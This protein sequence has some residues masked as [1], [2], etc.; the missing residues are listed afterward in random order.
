MG[1]R[2]SFTESRRR[3]AKQV[4]RLDRLE[5]RT[6]ITEPIS[7]TGLSITALRCLA[8]LGVTYPNGATSGLVR[9][10]GAARQSRGAAGDRLIV[11]GNVLTPILDFDAW[12]R[13]GAAGGSSSAASAA[14]HPKGATGDASGDWLT[15][16]SASLS[17]DQLREASSSI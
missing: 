5:S 3:L 4:D 13:A 10:A 1:F 8:Q 16:F 11:H 14:V 2:L 9:P 7:F 6:T 15:V 12:Q 17:G